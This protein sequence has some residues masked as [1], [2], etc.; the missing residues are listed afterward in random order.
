MRGKA[1]ARC[2]PGAGPLSLPAH[3]AYKSRVLR[4]VIS[5]S[6]AVALAT[7]ALDR[8][9]QIAGVGPYVHLGVAALFL[10][11]AVQMAQRQPRGLA[12]YG[13]LLG[14]LME[15]DPDADGERAAGAG[16]T[17]GSVGDLAGAIW[18]ALPHGLRAL[19]AALLTALVVFPPF[20]GAFYLYQGPGRPFGL[21]LPPEP[22]A[23]V[24]G[25]LLVVALP[26]EALFRGYLQGRLNER[27]PTEVKVLGVPLSPGATLLQCALFA[28]LHFVVEPYPARLAVFFPALLFTWL[29]RRQGGIGA[30]V[31]FHAMCNVLS[32][33]LARGWL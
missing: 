3:A 19:R 9:R 26:E 28:A 10:T 8:A 4:E 18:R 13:L 12:R 11:V 29:A 7:F 17:A 5:V 31:F 6:V 32:E 22:G 15:P 21:S 30:A 27:F 25:Q 16:P 23:F 14:G 33:L 2:V 24:L 1:L 20:I